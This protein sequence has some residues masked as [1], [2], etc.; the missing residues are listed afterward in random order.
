M[1]Q[2]FRC[3]SLTPHC[4]AFFSLL[5]TL[6]LNT[7]AFEQETVNEKKIMQQSKERTVGSG[8]ILRVVDLA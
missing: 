7:L 3:S 2:T 5:I 8:F 6:A 1:L 4:E